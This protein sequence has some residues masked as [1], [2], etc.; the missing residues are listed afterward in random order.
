VVE[1]QE[2]LLESVLLV[3]FD[4]LLVFALQLQPESR[5]YDYGAIEP[6]STA[7]AAHV[8]RKGFYSVFEMLQVLQ[9]VLIVAVDR[10]QDTH[11]VIAPL[12]EIFDI[13]AVVII[14]AIELEEVFEG[15]GFPQESLNSG[16]KFFNLDIEVV[17][18]DFGQAEE[19]ESLEDYPLVK[20]PRILLKGFNQVNVKR[21]IVLVPDDVHLGLVQ[22]ADV[23]FRSQDGT[24]HANLEFLHHRLHSPDVVGIEKKVEHFEMIVLEVRAFEDVVLLTDQLDAIDDLFTV[25]AIEVELHSY[26]TDVK[27]YLSFNLFANQRNFL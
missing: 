5:Y 23:V 15:E 11:I 20:V 26:S 12:P 17:L 7:L 14:N 9:H 21:R 22:I 13:I 6:L 4:D 1:V 2:A 27:I 18:I 8:S 16:N 10:P 19:V 3:Y 24:S 25:F